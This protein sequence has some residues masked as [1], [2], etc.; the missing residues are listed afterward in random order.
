MKK[1]IITAILAAMMVAASLSGCGSSTDSETE[2]KTEAVTEAA[3]EA[4]QTEEET[5]AV[6]EAAETEAAETEVAAEEV[7]DY[8]IKE[9]VLMVGMEIGY[10]P[11]EYFDEDGATPI[12]YDVEVATALAEELGLE[13]E[14]VDTAWDGIFAGVTTDK[15]DCIISSVSYTE[16]RDETYLLTAPYVANAP[17]IV[18]PND[19]DIADIMDLDGK[20]VAVQM[21][22]TADYLIQEYIADGLDTDLRQYEKVINAFDE[23]KA[24]RVDAVCT[25]SVVASYYL[26]DDASDYQTVWQ[27]EE[28]EPIVICLKKDN[29]ALE[30]KI[31]EGMAALFE[32]GTMAEL[33]V[34]YFGTE[35]V[36]EGL[37]E[38]FGVE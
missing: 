26:G 36:I 1:R 33:A 31:N 15:Y 23:I 30:A 34:K 10:P 13:L 22:T 5:E 19:S 14:I 18:V 38:G 12:G 28:K 9:G 20:T 25:D 32:N 16:D 2:A 3:T 11:M 6:T 35:D 21:E 37:A 8:T 24:G 7:S 4:V 29:E 17:V 27:A